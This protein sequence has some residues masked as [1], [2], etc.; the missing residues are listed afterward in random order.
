MPPKLPS[1]V[2]YEN[3][4]LWREKPF[5]RGQFYHRFKCLFPP[6]TNLLYVPAE[7]YSRTIIMDKTFC[8]SVTR[9]WIREQTKF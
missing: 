9:K 7:A 2:Q 4:I 5:K 1:A 8:T 6:D 3:K